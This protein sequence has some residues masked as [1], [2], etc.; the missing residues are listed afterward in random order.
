M[1]EGSDCTLAKHLKSPENPTLEC[2]IGVCEGSNCT[3]ENNQ[4]QPKIRPS[5]TPREGAEG[6]VGKEGC[7][8][9]KRALGGGG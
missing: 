6:G 4:N 9:R 3:L 8:G 2:P 7:G 1:Y 5:H